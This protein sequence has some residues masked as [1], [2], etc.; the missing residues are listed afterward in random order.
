MKYGL[1][2]PAYWFRRY[3][4]RQNVH[5]TP[6]QDYHSSEDKDRP[7]IQHREKV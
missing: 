2:S 1:A 6:L 7:E 3:V 4:L 5:R